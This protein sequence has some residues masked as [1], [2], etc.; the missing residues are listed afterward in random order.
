[1]LSVAIA[2][3]GLSMLSESSVDLNLA[4]K[5]LGA[6]DNRRIG[7]VFAFTLTDSPTSFSVYRASR[8]YD[9]LKEVLNVGDIVT[10]YSVNSATANL[11]VSQIEKNGQ[12]I[13]DKHLLESQNMAGGLI[14]LLGGVLMAA[15]GI[16]QFRRNK[17]L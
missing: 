6:I 5:N 16:W 15:V 10:V 2:L 4:V 11:Q 14:A 9:D 17:I 1:M 8:N 3:V 7:K 12:V 13:V